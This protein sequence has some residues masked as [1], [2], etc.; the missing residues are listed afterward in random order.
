MVRHHSAHLLNDHLCHGLL[1]AASQ[2]LLPLD[3]AP[4]YVYMP[5][6]AVQPC[7]CWSSLLVADGEEDMSHGPKNLAVVTGVVAASGFIAGLLGADL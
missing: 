5:I 2:W 3:N 4:S 7:H 1:C 6:R